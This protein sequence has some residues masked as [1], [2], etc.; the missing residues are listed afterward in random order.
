MNIILMGYR[1]CGKTSIGR[2]IADQT[3]KE[4]VDVDVDV[5]KRFEN[6]SIAEIW[7]TD[8][9]PAFRPSKWRS[10]RSWWPAR[11]MSSG[12]GAAR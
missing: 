5:C 4:F 11:T 3:W 2:K 10:P 6:R 12:S 9:E 8:G 1:G 7:Q